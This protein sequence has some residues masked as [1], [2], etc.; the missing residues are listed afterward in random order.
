M[1]KNTY[2]MAWR[3]KS[4]NW[5]LKKF[6]PNSKG[7]DMSDKKAFHVTVRVTTATKRRVELMRKMIDRFRQGEAMFDELAELI[8]FSPSGTRGY[9]KELI[10]ADLVFLDR[11]INVVARSIGQAV[12][13]L[14]DNEDLVDA[15][16]A[17][18]GIPQPERAPKERIAHGLPTDPTRHFHIVQDD[19]S[20]PVKVA[21]L[22]APAPDPLLAQFFGF[23]GAV[24]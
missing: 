19:S 3:R 5:A 2:G 16:I 17:S 1:R 23:A 6:Y 10:D 22:N 8:G 14:T 21:R 20:Y 15:Y 13:V 9:L 12:Y 18:M 11:R 7:N 24:A 4:P